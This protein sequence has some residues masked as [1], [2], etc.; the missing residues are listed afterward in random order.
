[1]TDR[2]TITLVLDERETAE[3]QRIADAASDPLNPD[4]GY[5]VDRET[6]GRLVRLHDDERSRIVDWLTGHGLEII[7]PPQSLSQLFFARGT[8][9]QIVSALG[10]TIESWIAREPEMRKVRKQLAI[11]RDI[12]GTIIKVAGLPGEQ[13]QLGLDRGDGGDPLDD[14]TVIGKSP[15]VQP[16]DLRGFTPADVEEI[17][18]FPTDWTGKGETIAILTLGGEIDQGDLASFWRA[19]GIEP[20]VVHSVQIGATSGK[21]PHPLESFEITA[22]VEWI[23]AMAP[24]SEIVVYSADPV[25]MGDPWS[26]FLLA[27]LGDREYAP[28]VAVMPRIT[29]ERSYYRIHGHELITGLLDQ[30]AAIGLTVISAAGDWGSFDGVPRTVRENRFVGDAPWPHGTFPAVEERIL[31]VGGTMITFREPLTEVAWSAPPPIAIRNAVPFERIAGS[32]GFS[33]DVP[34]P[35]WQRD[36]LRSHYARGASS[37]A[38][39]PYGRGF[40]D[41]AIA[42]SGPTI[43]RAPEEPPSAIG[44]QALKSGRW[45]DY[46]CGTAIGASIWA[47]IIARAN[48]ARRD[49]GL[50]RVGFVN[51]LLYKLRDAKPSPYRDVTLGAADVIMNVIS[52]SGRAVPYHIHGYECAPDWNP[53]SGLGVPRVSTLIEHLRRKGIGK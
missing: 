39:V 3:I 22:A 41:V 36:V 43:Q 15:G 32:G 53:V 27:V 16:I 7:E 26:A 37:P 5:H 23:G 48:E 17:Y 34:I 1:M 30:A 12:A 46:A 8:A 47:A 11:P 42:A 14:A 9:E 44:Y 13:G 6:L 45:V 2:I 10:G 40:P 49:A 50:P 25:V 21:A 52:S 24:G 20:P 4:Y 29:P 38:V 31:A 18:D 35:T 28:T 33:E 51:P 19:H